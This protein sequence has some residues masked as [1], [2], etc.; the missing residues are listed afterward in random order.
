MSYHPSPGPGPRAARPSGHGGARLSRQGKATGQ[1]LLVISA[2][3]LVA[4][5][6]AYGFFV[7]T[8]P[9]QRIDNAL[10][11]GQR[12][13]LESNSSAAE[14]LLRS[15]TVGALVVGIGIAVLVPTLR[16]R[17]RL[18]LASVAVIGTS[19][20]ANELLKEYLLTHPPLDDVPSY[21]QQNSFPSG[22]TT[23]AIAAGAALVLGVPYRLRGAA[24]LG[25]AGFATVIGTAT[26]RAAWHRLSDLIGSYLL[27]L[28]IVATT[29]A[30][31]AFWRDVSPPPPATGASQRWLSGCLGGLVGAAAVVGVIGG[32][33]VSFGTLAVTAFRGEYELRGTRSVDVVAL[34]FWVVVVSV[35]LLAALGAAR[36]PPHQRAAGGIAAAALTGAGVTALLGG[37]ATLGATW[38]ELSVGFPGELALLWAYRLASFAG[39]GVCFL[40]VAALLAGLAR[41]ELD[42]P[43]QRRGPARG[44]EWTE[45]PE[46]LGPGAAVLPDSALPPHLQQPQRPYP[47]QP[48]PPGLPPTSVYP[49]SADPGHPPGAPPPPTRPVW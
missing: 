11:S 40:A 15:F 3:A 22:H 21:L 18:A 5:V 26:M 31:L 7:R 14:E 35:G 43:R 20:L 49:P 29:A 44:A 36:R 28:T 23:T 41:A 8:A 13:D 33:V 12:Y 6:S 4:L 1:R 48:Y 25:A 24:A 42:P 16:R 47:Q 39:H 19:M 17:P 38:R 2:L 34:A 9:G 30:I 46:V 10:L 27:V 37:A 45:R 32:L